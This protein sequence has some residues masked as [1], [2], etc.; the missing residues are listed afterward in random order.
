MF[1]SGTVVPAEDESE[2]DIQIGS[3]HTHARL[4]FDDDED[5]LE[6]PPLQHSQTLS[7]VLVLDDE[8]N[9]SVASA[10][11]DA[12]SS[13]TPP[14]PPPK[15][16]DLVEVLPPSAVTKDDPPSNPRRQTILGMA[17]I[18]LLLGIIVGLAVAFGLRK[19]S[20]EPA[21]SIAPTPT[22]P[23][24][25]SSASTIQ[26]IRERGTLRCGYDVVPAF[27]YVDEDTGEI[28]GFEAALCHAIAAALQV[29]AELVGGNVWARFAWLSTGDLDVMARGLTH[30]M[31]RDYWRT[32]L[33]AILSFS[34]PYFYA[35]MQAAG[36]PFYVHNCVAQGFKHVEECADLMVCV[37]GSGSTHQ[38]KLKDFLPSRRTVVSGDSVAEVLASFA[39]GDCNVMVHEGQNLA[40]PLVREAGYTGDYVV[41]DRL[42]SKEP[43][44]LLTRNSDPVFAD[45]VN[46]VL[47]SLMAAEQ[48]GIAQSTANQFPPTSLVFAQGSIDVNEDETTF[49][50]HYPDMFRD[51]IRAVGNYG[52]IYERFL[53]GHAPRQVLNTIYSNEETDHHTGLLFTLPFGEIERVGGEEYIGPKVLALLDQGYLRCGVRMGRPGLGWLEEADG[54]NATSTVY[55]GMDVD[56]CRAL[57]ASLFAGDSNRV[58]FVPL[59]DVGAGAQLLMQNEVDVVAGAPWSLEM[60][61]Q[62]PSTGVGFSLSQ[63]YLYGSSRYGTMMETLCMMTRQDDYAWSAFVFWVV[64]STIYAEENG[65]DSESSNNMPEVLYLGPK[66]KRMLRGAVLAVGS[67]AEIYERNLQQLVPR[68]APNTLNGK[69]PSSWGPQH[70]PIQGFV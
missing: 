27:G 70:Y 28:T 1:P 13:T 35:G 42:Y 19:S 52:E 45:F 68:Q 40:E 22:T 58:E 51:A 32:Q 18:L 3:N 26:R 37:T 7:A 30:T 10:S 57:A 33:G 64:S 66:F 60:D 14:Q 56:Y 44:C 63:P 15:Q 48:H 46:A 9:S 5:G 23:S 36:D 34:V 38:K 4:P 65:I 11:M 16:D 20:S 61:V 55:S 49:S 43:L 12:S 50:Y 53:G 2:N 59:E 17:V 41:A 47:Q 25:S 6:A 24:F 69:P 54:G 67:Y 21:V 39:K 8:D 31:E 29:E 62:E